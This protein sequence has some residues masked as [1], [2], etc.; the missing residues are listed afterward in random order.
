MLASTI[1]QGTSTI[2]Y[3]P[4][5]CNGGSPILNYTVLI[6]GQSSN[7]YSVGA[8]VVPITVTSLTSGSN[9]LFQVVA[10]NAVGASKPSPSA[11]PL[12]SELIVSFIY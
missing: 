10:Y 5:T 12:I 6:N 8:T 2:R 7:F 9:Y 4:S 1:T 11:Q 3:T